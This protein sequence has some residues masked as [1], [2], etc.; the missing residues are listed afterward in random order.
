MTHF[1]ERQDQLR[2]GL[3]DA[4]L[5]ELIPFIE[6]QTASLPK[7]F[8]TMDNRV[9]EFRKRSTGEMAKASVANTEW[10]LFYHPFFQ[11][12]FRVDGAELAPDRAAAALKL[13]AAALAHGGRLLQRPRSRPRPRRLRPTCRRRPRIR[14]RLM[15]RTSPRPGFR[16]RRRTRPRPSLPRPGPRPRRPSR[17]RPRAGAV[18]LDACPSTCPAPPTSS[19]RSW[20]CGTRQPRHCCAGRAL[21]PGA[22]TPTSSAPPA[23]PRYWARPARASTRPV[24]GCLGIGPGKTSSAPRASPGRSTQR[25]TASARPALRPGPR[26]SDPRPR[27]ALRIAGGGG[28]R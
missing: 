19:A 23:S 20:L 7:L 17:R 1:A 26:A 21:P 13:A 11:E 22:R 2:R 3:W 8:S 15:E 9:R 18:P 14:T 24:P 28:P 10:M 16:L 25:A 27:P 6:A 5:S 4:N 12:I